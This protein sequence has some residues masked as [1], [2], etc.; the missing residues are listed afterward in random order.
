MKN[1]IYRIRNRHLMLVDFFAYVI[2]YC[3]TIML[4]SSSFDGFLSCAK[5][6]A[7]PFCASVVLIAASSCF[8]GIYSVLWRYC[9]FKEGI[10]L[11]WSAAIGAALT[12]IAFFLYELFLMP[13]VF[14]GARITFGYVKFACCYAF[15]IA[16]STIFVRALAFVLYRYSNYLKTRGKGYSKRILIV[17]AGYSAAAMIHDLSRNANINYDIVGLV[18]D[19][20]E[21]KNMTISGYRVLGGRNDIPQI[22]R[23][24]KVEEILLAVPSAT[25]AQRKSLIEICEKTDCKI[26]T[27][28]SIDQTIGNE[29][30]KMRDIE[31]EDLL[32]RDE[33][34][35]SVGEIEGYIREKK[36]LITGGGGSIGSELCR[37]V[38]KFNPKELV[39]VDI[40]ENNA[41][42][43]Q[44]E[45]CE[46]F[47]ENKPMVIIASVRDMERLENIFMQ[48]KPDVVFHAA[49]HK[50]VPLMED[51]P[52]EAI[53]NNILGTYNVAKCADKFGCRKFVMISTD[54]AVNPT[55]IMGATKRMCEM[56][57]EA[58][59]HQS[60][61][62]FVSVRFGN[63]L[64]SNGSVVPLFRKQI[65][66]GGPVTITH[67]EITRFFMSIPEA[68]QLVIQ[69]GAFAK[70][71]EIFVLDM[72]KPVKIYDLAKNIIRLSGYK[73]GIDI[74]IKEI[75]LRPGEKL[76]EELLMDEEKL[77][78]TPHSQ[79]F[80]G[81][82]IDVSMEKIKEHIKRLAEAADTQDKAI[83]RQALHEA[84]PTFKEPELVNPVSVSIH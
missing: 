58:M 82:Q 39:I 41:Y 44:M 36:I 49:A 78:A 66:K 6:F 64:G 33:I 37:Q 38:M 17:G 34:K 23:D 63:V 27:L 5:L 60:K 7:I 45:L 11:F 35:L 75:G 14:E 59:Q 83:I 18:D 30:Y 65:E 4:G 9:S 2:A 51:S 67:K 46:K 76:Y 57:V 15:L 31:I 84:V 56:I 40:Y 8:C 50:H 72:G 81:K 79:I 43:I 12:V 61:T 10:Q 13:Y 74:E 54:K 77:R 29:K 71:G 68:A 3:L 47:P 80:I 52:T 26:K 42:D 22:C 19:D 73:P 55:N 70:G 21:K 20:N 48:Y 16:C 32:E 1:F 53:R 25:S 28:P 62:E 24:Y 69:A